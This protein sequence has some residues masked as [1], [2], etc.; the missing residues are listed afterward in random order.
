M[1]KVYRPMSLSALYLL[2]TKML[3][4]LV[5]SKC[6]VFCFPTNWY[7]GIVGGDKGNISAVVL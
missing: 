5:A 7:V 2:V 3:H 6:G 1:S 4:L